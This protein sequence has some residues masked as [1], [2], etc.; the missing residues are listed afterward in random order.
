M[1]NPKANFNTDSFFDYFHSYSELRLYTIILRISGYEDKFIHN[2][3]SRETL[4][5]LTN[6]SEIHVMELLRALTVNK[7]LKKGK[8]TIYYY[9]KEL[10]R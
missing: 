2:R 9:N 7:V 5:E 10:L 4:A 3:K 6:F 1:N 8:R